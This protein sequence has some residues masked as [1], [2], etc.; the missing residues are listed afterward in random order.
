MMIDER[1]HGRVSAARFDAL[2]LAGE[3]A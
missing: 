2:V 1:L 3:R